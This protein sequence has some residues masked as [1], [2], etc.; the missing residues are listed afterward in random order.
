MELRD[1]LS[2]V[3]LTQAE[4]GLQTPLLPPMLWD[5]SLSTAPS[6]PFPPTVTPAHPVDDGFPHTT[7][8]NT[9]SLPVRQARQSLSP[10]L[11]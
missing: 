3:P 4:M 2:L 6:F 11:S 7:C 1:H 5:R 8:S 9:L 10:S